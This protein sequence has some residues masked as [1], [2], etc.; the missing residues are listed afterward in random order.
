MC[1]LIRTSLAMNTTVS[2]VF[3]T[4]R[5]SPSEA[6]L[7]HCAFPHKRQRTVKDGLCRRAC[8]KLSGA[9]YHFRSARILRGGWK[10]IL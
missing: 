3:M 6:A 2:K 4:I 7:D 9:A 1:T 5:M 8:V 10:I